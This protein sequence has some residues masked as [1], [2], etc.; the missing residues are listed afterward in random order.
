MEQNQQS[1]AHDIADRVTHVV[2]NFK[3]RFLP[4]E[5]EIGDHIH[6]HGLRSTAGWPG[7]DEA[8]ILG[9]NG[10]NFWLN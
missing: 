5:I 1:L 7:L 9:S 3:A 6:P 4:S 10:T 2:Q 8:A